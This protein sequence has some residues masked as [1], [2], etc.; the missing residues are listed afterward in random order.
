MVA[1]PVRSPCTVSR[2]TSAVRV[3]GGGVPKNFH[4]GWGSKV[5]SITGLTS[6]FWITSTRSFSTRWGS[7]MRIWTGVRRPIPA[8]AG[9]TVTLGVAPE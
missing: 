6:E 8:N 7:S 1:S 2:P 3:T 9:L 5:F 4:A